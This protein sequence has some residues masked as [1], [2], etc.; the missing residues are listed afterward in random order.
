MRNTIIPHH[1][2]RLDRRYFDNFAHVWRDCF[3]WSTPP[4]YHDERTKIFYDRNIHDVTPDSGR[5]RPQLETRQ[6]VNY[7]DG[8]HYLKYYVRAASESADRL[9]QAQWASRNVFATYF[10]AFLAYLMMQVLGI[11]SALDDFMNEVS[12]Y[13][14]ENYRPVLG[15]ILV[16]L[17]SSWMMSNHPWDVAPQV[18]TSPAATQFHSPPVDDVRLNAI[19]LNLSEM[20]KIVSAQQATIGQLANNQEKLLTSLEASAQRMSEMSARLDQLNAELTQM[21]KKK[22]RKK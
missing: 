10:Y 3:P 12:Y 21:R 15:V 9:T 22:L 1:L 17:I 20:S 6:I 4:Q 16:A 13:A 14:V 11:F 2:I 5:L 19:S 7:G 8:Y 18:E